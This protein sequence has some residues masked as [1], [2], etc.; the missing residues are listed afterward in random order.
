VS[1]ID[2]FI[3]ARLEKEG[4]SP[5]AVAD[6]RTL[7]RRVT[8]DLTGLPPTPEEVKAAAEKPLGARQYRLIGA[9][10]FTPE[11]HK[12]HRLV[13]KGLLTK[14]GSDPGINLTSFQMLS[15]TC[16]K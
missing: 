16:A 5:S 7:L 11:S 4:I 10:P 3:L 9:S 8:Y 6:R 13:V 15:E 1:E 12:G 14:S 2:R